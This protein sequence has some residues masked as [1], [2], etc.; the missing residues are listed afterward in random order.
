MKVLNTHT[1]NKKYIKENAT[2]N[3][4]LNKKII[5]QVLES[6]PAK[7]ALEEALERS[8]DNHLHPYVDLKHDC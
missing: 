8:P 1:Y 4:V 3:S 2:Q 6:M 7:I 5:T